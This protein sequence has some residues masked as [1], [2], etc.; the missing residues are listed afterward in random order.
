[1]KY[2]KPVMTIKELKAM[3][4]P[5]RQLRSAYHNKLNE[6]KQYAWKMT[7]SPKSTIYFDTEEFDKIRKYI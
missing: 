1:M 2:P 7:D 5:E 6:D 4:F 3:G